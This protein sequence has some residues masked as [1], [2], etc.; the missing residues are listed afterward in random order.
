MPKIQDIFNAGTIKARFF[1]KSSQQDIMVIEEVTLT[2]RSGSIAARDIAT[3]TLQFVGIY[4]YD[5][6]GEQNAV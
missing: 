3:E 6:S 4:Y 2:G 5:E 1:D